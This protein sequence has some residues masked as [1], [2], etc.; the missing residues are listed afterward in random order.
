M[1]IFSRIASGF[2]LQDRG[3]FVYISGNIFSFISL[4]FQIILMQNT[5]FHQVLYWKDIMW[6]FKWNIH[7]LWWGGKSEEGQWNNLAES[8]WVMTLFTDPYASISSHLWRPADPMVFLVVLWIRL[9][10]PAPSNSQLLWSPPQ[11]HK[12]AH[13]N[14]HR[15]D[16]MLLLFHPWFAF[17]TWF[18]APV[19][20]WSTGTGPLSGWWVLQSAWNKHPPTA[21]IILCIWVCRGA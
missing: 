19:L 3:M 17:L 11:T 10:S 20:L 5:L 21:I 12:Q 6:P 14:T 2:H 8:P 1:F 9:R 13:M 16:R 15:F 4:G 18:C 7:C